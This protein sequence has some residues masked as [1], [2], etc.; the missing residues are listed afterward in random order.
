[1]RRIDSSLS[2][3]TLLAALLLV[4]G[5]SPYAYETE[6]KGFASGV[7]QLRAG[8]EAGISNAAADRA[9][10][11]TLI[12]KQQR[13]RL[14]LADTCIQA[15]S[16]PCDLREQGAVATTDVTPEQA[17]AA[18]SPIFDALQRY[19]DAL[20]AVTAATDRQAFD[21]AQTELASAVGDT[22]AKAKAS[23]QTVAEA[24]AAAS[25]VTTVG[26]IVLDTRR[27]A[28]L[29]AGVLAAQDAVP[30]LAATLGRQMNRLRDVRIR[31]LTEQILLLDAPLGPRFEPAAYADRL[32]RLQDR[33]AVLNALRGTDPA[34]A[35]DD[36]AKAHE[37]L[38]RALRDDT[39]QIAP[40][41]QAVTAF[42][43][44]AKG[45]HDAFAAKPATK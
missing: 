37:A 15:S 2:G 29:R 32:D 6:V 19:A 33:V 42:V 12:W 8:Y 3:L 10:V 44:A 30:V 13:P 4:V 41:A 18:A 40:V 39:R 31:E 20:A 17:A 7:G 27:Y 43:K 38:V 14:A 5:C 24:S 11:Q 28:A 21:A 26:G 23:N 16:E 36:M 35:A 45:M 25:L 34:K 9:A 22:L 1:M